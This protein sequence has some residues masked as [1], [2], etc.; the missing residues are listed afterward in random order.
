MASAIRSSSE[1][2]LAAL[3]HVVLEVCQLVAGVRDVRY[4]VDPAKSGSCSVIPMCHVPHWRIQYG[5]RDARAAHTMLDPPMLTRRLAS[6][7]SPARVAN[8][9]RIPLMSSA[10]RAKRAPHGVHTNVVMYG[11]FR[12]WS[13]DVCSD[14]ISIDFGQDLCFID[15]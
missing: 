6:L 12:S 7:A 1:E 8:L 5:V 10:H 14:P 9:T 4:H 15:M 13:L 11:N 3:V 2:R